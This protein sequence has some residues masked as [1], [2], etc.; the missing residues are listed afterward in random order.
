MAQLISAVELWQ[1]ETSL[2]SVPTFS[3]SL[4][5]VFGSDGVQLNTMNE[6]LGLPGSGKTQLCIQLCASIQIPTILGGLD[7]EALYIDTN[8]NFTAKRFKE[9]VVGSLNRCHK[10]LENP[11][12]VDELAALRRLHYVN[13]FGLEKFCAFMYQL[14]NV[15]NKHDKIKLIV[16]DSITFPFKVGISSTQ[17]TGLL[18]RQMAE[19]QK[20]AVQKQ[21]AIVMTNE[22]S[23]RMGLSSGPL[24]GS[25]GD[26]WAHRCNK[27]VLLS[28]DEHDAS[29][30]I[31]LCLKSNNSP[32]TVGRFRIT[33]DGIRDI[34][35]KT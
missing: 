29:N 31:A 30:R 2:P 33:Q 25:L 8:T 19:L 27:R 7:A 1:N 20:L 24:V 3:Q 5:K 21:I 26:A 11:A 16:I 9:T 12:E 6:L 17:R 15:I 32:N 34:E 35:T 28:H 14:P 23:T 4:D 18:F 10:L 13:A 22:M